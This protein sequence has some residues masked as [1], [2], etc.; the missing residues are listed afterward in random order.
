MLEDF[1]SLRARM[2]REGL[3]SSSTSFYI[4]KAVSLLA[5]YC[6]VAMMLASAQDTWLGCAAA[7]FMLGLCW[8]QTGWLSHDFLHHQVFKNRVLNT[9]VGYIQGNLLQG[10]S[11]DWWKNKHNKHHAVPNECDAH[12]HA[13][14][15]GALCCR[16]KLSLTVS[17]H[18]HGPSRCAA[19]SEGTSVH[20]LAGQ[21][22][23]IDA[24][25]S[26]LAQHDCVALCADIDTLP[27]LAWHEDMLQDVSP[28][29]A[30]LLRRQHTLFFPI[31]CLARFSWAQQSALH[32]GVLA[33]VDARGWAESAL[34]AGHY[35]VFAGLPLFA[36][37]PL[38]ALAFFALAQV[39]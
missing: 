9:A 16:R 15:P 17:V 4:Y 20:T 26:L 10:F 34:L 23:H 18:A 11:V 19:A 21:S 12:A 3:F 39:R 27:L 25:L 24:L 35:A 6:T 36:L 8:Q 5:M 22:T 13:V 14:D 37:S 33:R 38:K 1:R 30:A 2:R 32:A 7:A 28:P 31:M 29:L